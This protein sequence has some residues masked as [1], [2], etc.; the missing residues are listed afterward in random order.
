MEQRKAIKQTPVKLSLLQMLAAPS[1]PFRFPT[2]K[3]AVTPP[4]KNNQIA[5][6]QTDGK[7]LG[8]G[9]T[10][11][12]SRHQHAAT[13]NQS[14]PAAV[15]SW[16]LHVGNSFP[17]EQQAGQAACTRATIIACA[18]RPIGLLGKR[19][20][21]TLK[22][23]TGTGGL[24]P[25]QP[26]ASAIAAGSNHSWQRGSNTLKAEPHAPVEGVLVLSDTEACKRRRLQQPRKQLMAPINHYEKG[27]EALGCD[28][29]GIDGV[30]DG[31][32]DGLVWE[33]AGAIRV[34]SHFG[35]GVD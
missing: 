19:A 17:P 12:N 33:T 1:T 31:G 5:N 11:L 20:P 28:T 26:L 32:P 35:L 23:H 34:H 22:K 2:S 18:A 13:G 14:T 9:T 7:N 6:G 10:P 15:D 30:S 21:P 25:Q 4:G 16:S 24:G 8:S 27:S 3:H 29:L